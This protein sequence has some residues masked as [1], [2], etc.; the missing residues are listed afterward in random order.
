MSALPSSID[1]NK[2]SIELR[3]L[4]AEKAI[5]ITS[6]IQNDGSN[7]Y[8][9]EVADRMKQLNLSFDNVLNDYNN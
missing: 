6:N 1:K 7:S 3:R 5:M 4:E 8:D 2:K 9:R